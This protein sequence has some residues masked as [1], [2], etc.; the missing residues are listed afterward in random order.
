LKEWL[1]VGSATLPQPSLGEPENAADHD[2]LQPCAFVFM[3]F[4]VHDRAL[5]PQT[6][7]GRRSR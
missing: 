6:R 7:E 3:R 1:G 2:E 5:T 4:I